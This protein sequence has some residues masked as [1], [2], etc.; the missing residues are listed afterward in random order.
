MFKTNPA[1]RLKLIHLSMKSDSVND[2]LRGQVSC[3]GVCLSSWLVMVLHCIQTV[4]VIQGG[5][6]Q[7]YLDLIEDTWRCFT[8][9]SC[10]WMRAE[11]SSSIKT[12][13]P[14]FDPPWKYSEAFLIFWPPHVRKQQKPLSHDVDNNSSSAMN[15]KTSSYSRWSE[16]ECNQVRLLI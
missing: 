14:R 12:S 5:L 3:S 6:N 2:P 1:G 9:F 16:S 10:S 7:G 4:R 11:T 13:G 8:F 15:I